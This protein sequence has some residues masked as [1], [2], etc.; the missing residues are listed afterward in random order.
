MTE[1][2]ASDYITR[3]EF[4]A[5]VRRL[6]ERSEGLLRLMASESSRLNAAMKSEAD[7]INALLVASA[8]NVRLANTRAELTAANLA[9]RV[10]NSAKALAGQVEGTAKANVEA[11]AAAA[12]A[13]STRIKPLEEQ[14]FSDAGRSGITTPML[15]AFCVFAGGL[16]LYLIQLL[17]K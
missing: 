11:V 12:L 13:M 16:A 5:E 9:E 14:R 17:M 8:D 3:R 7:R 2:G 10:E 1:I 4:Q 6:D 15:A